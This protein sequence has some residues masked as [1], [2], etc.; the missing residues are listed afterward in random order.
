MA[1]ASGPGSSHECPWS[2]RSAATYDSWKSPERDPQAGWGRAAARTLPTRVGTG[3]R[4][5]VTS[6]RVGG[7]GSTPTRAAAT[8]TSSS[9]C[10]CL[11]RTPCQAARARDPGHHMLRLR[12]QCAMPY[13]PMAT[14]PHGARFRATSRRRVRRFQ[15]HPDRTGPWTSRPHVGSCEDEPPQAGRKGFGPL[16]SGRPTEDP[17]ARPKITPPPTFS[18]GCSS[19]SPRTTAP[20]GGHPRRWRKA[21]A[22]RARSRCARRRR[23]TASCG[24]PGSLRDGRPDNR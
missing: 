8:G 2:R 20:R 22:S 1:S 4:P 9:A 18:P 7:I 16:A 3:C 6:P 13:M 12:G 11:D 23:G 19:G 10:R 17:V 24:C 21:P 15:P 14:R 5:S